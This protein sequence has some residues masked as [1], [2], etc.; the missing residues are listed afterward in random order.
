MVA[1]PGTSVPGLA[2]DRVRLHRTL[3]EGWIRLAWEM[4]HA[5]LARAWPQKPSIPQQ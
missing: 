2:P 1:V 3:T 5:T 4:V